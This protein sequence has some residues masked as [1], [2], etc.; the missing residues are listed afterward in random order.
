M[1]VDEQKAMPLHLGEQD[2]VA[3]QSAGVVGSRARS[4]L[5]GNCRRLAASVRA[6]RANELESNNDE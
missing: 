3:T 1:S 4:G 5:E 2:A 6:G